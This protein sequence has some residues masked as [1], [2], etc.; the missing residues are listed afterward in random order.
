MTLK[1]DERSDLFKQIQ[2]LERH[3]FRQEQ[4]SEPIQGFLEANVTRQL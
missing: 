3:A 4:I 2:M 1:A